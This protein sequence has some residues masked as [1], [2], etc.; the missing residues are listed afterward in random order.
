MPIT[1]LSADLR[2]IPIMAASPLLLVADL[3]QLLAVAH[4]LLDVDDIRGLRG[5][6]QIPFEQIERRGILAL[7]YNNSPI[8]LRRPG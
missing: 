6:L 5:L 4:T 2:G 3:D 7:R 1:V 8:N